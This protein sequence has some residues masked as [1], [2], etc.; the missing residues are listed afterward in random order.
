MSMKRRVDLI[1]FDLDGTLADTGADLADAVN[2][3]R[4]RFDLPPLAAAQIHAHVGLGVEHLLRHTLPIKNAEHFRHVLEVFLKRYEAHLLDKTVLYPG[5]QDILEYFSGK[6]RVVATNKVQRLAEAV[7]RGLGIGESFDLILGGDSAAAKKPHPALLTM[8]LERFQ[9]TPSS[10]VMVG[11]GEA[12]IEAGKRAGVITC[13]VR[14][15]L[16]DKDRLSAAK[17]DLMI[18]HLGELRGHFC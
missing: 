18:D 4:A 2:F 1:L 13:A 12:D 15:G 8:A 17:P 11:D 14:Y 9:T 10:A 3:T 7:V 16:G 5:A 6:R